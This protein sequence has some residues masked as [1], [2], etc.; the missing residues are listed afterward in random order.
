MVGVE[1]V[2]GFSLS[3]FSS[4]LASDS[5]SPAGV[6]RTVFSSFGSTHSIIMFCSSF[7]F[8]A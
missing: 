8:V 1:A 7:L 2:Q 6:W 3:G 5:S 4:D